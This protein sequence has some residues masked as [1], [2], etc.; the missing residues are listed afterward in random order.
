[1]LERI[2]IPSL[3]SLEQHSLQFVAKV[4]VSCEA[5]CACVFVTL[6][7]RLLRL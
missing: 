7:S 6:I 1:M 4:L 3:L 2:A 5:D